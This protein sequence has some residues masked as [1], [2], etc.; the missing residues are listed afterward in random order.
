MY[1]FLVLAKNLPY[2]PVSKAMCLVMTTYMVMYV[3][4]SA[5]YLTEIKIAIINIS[6]RNHYDLKAITRIG[7]SNSPFVIVDHRYDIAV[8]GAVYA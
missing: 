2:Q 8:K 1:M 5:G 7:K 3:T 4:L 6:V